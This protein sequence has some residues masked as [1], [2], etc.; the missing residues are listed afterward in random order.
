MDPAVSLV[1]TYLYTNGY[2]T[3]TEYPV[4]ELRGE[5]QVRSSTDIDVLAVRFPFAARLVPTPNDTIADDL[6][7]ST[8]DPAL[9]PSD[10]LIDFIIAEV[11]E[12]RA[13]LNRGATKSHVL[14][15][16]LVRCG[17]FHENEIE[18]L[19]KQLIRKGEAIHQNRIRVRLMAFGAYRDQRDDREYTV[20]TLRQILDHLDQLVKKHADAIAAAQFKD[21]VIAMLML[22]HKARLAPKN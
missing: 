8:I 19:V 3:L 7:V 5:D 13:E 6:L 14:R 21:P 1:Q 2:F 18:P 9:D 11:K 16:A 15:T 20:I 12:G 22:L 10:S 17:T 4:I